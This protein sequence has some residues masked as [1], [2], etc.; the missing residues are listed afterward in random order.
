MPRGKS[1]D[2]VQFFF[3]E[4]L[5]CGSKIARATLTS[6]ASSSYGSLRAHLLPVV[7]GTSYGDLI[8]IC[9]D[10][11]VDIFLNLDCRFLVFRQKFS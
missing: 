4:E 6:S 10:C 8:M 2:S 11:G 9:D 1:Y 7:F 5:A 3:F